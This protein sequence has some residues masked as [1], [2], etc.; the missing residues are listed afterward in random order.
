MANY[1]SVKRRQRDDLH[2]LEKKR[3]I[4]DNE[5]RCLSLSEKN[6]N[7]PPQGGE[8]VS[9]RRERS[10]LPVE[11]RGGPLSMQRLNVS[12]LSTATGGGTDPLSG[13]ILMCP[14]STETR[15]TIPC[16]DNVSIRERS[17]FPVE[18]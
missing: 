2:S 9:L 17:V 10:V 12:L 3:T 7:L 5:E 1:I 18:G 8:S 6:E 16:T 15:Q 14:S 4:L 11:R 13:K